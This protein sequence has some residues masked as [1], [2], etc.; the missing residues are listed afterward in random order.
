MFAATVSPRASHASGGTQS[1]PAV[2]K[3]FAILEVLANSQNGL[4]LR[5][6][7]HVCHLPKSTVHCILITLQRSGYLHRKPRTSRYLF[8]RKLLQLA[9]HALSGIEVCDQAEPHM[10]TLCARLRLPVQLGIIES[11]E[12]T[13]VTKVDHF[14]RIRSLNSWIGKRMELHCT[15]IGKALISDWS[16]DEIYRRGRERNL[17]RHNDNTICTIKGLSEEIEKVRRNGFAVDD[18]E[19]VLGVRCIGAPI[20][21]PAGHV[22]AAI[23][24]YGETWEITEENVGGIAAQVRV[25]AEAIAHSLC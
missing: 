1:V 9:N 10:R 23:S 12:V 18:E 20:H 13:I 19:D 14:S 4:T 24:V 25:A 11:G 16:A 6:L 22:A 17:S 8:G 5:E 3:V 7:A 21:D 15:A 2:E